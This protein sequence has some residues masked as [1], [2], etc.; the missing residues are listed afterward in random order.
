MDDLEAHCAGEQGCM[1]DPK[2][3]EYMVTHEKAD[4]ALDR[5]IK[6][7]LRYYIGKIKIFLEKYFNY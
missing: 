7:P 5:A 4:D 6:S 3:A 1:P 2:V